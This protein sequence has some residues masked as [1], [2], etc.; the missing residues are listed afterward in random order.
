MKDGKLIS[1]PIFFMIIR[2]FA[3]KVFAALLNLLET[4]LS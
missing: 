4:K 1:C 2:D 3:N